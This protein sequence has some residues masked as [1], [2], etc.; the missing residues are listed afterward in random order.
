M[1][2][3]TD[4]QIINMTIS[5]PSIYGFNIDTIRE[6]KI[7]YDSIGLSDVLIHEPKQ[8]IQ[9]VEL[10]Y[11][12]YMY[13]SDLGIEIDMKNYKLLFIPQKMFEKKYGFTKDELMSKYV[14]L[15]N[16]ETTIKVR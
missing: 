4:E 11:A 5:L 1:L 7:F 6:K 16:E 10:S 14:Y 3:Y 2:G 12:R 13:Y 15:K 9:S 8:M